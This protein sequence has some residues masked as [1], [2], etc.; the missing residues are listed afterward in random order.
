MVFHREHYGCSVAYEKFSDTLYAS[1][2][3]PESCSDN[4]SKATSGKRK[5]KSFFN[6]NL[7]GRFKT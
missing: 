6:N 2:D 4:H 1:N 5:K 3:G 7:P